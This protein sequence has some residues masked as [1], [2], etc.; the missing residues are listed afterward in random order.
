MMG[1]W[2]KP[3]Q[4]RHIHDMACKSNSSV[5]VMQHG[6]NLRIGNARSKQELVVSPTGSIIKE[7]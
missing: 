3:K 1:V 4:I 5:Y 2:I 6:N 7:K